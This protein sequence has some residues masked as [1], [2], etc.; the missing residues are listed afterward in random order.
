MES[1]NDRTLLKLLLVLVFAF[2]AVAFTVPDAEAYQ[3]F[4]ADTDGGTLTNCEACHPSLTDKGDGHDLHQNGTGLGCSDCHGGGLANRDA[5]PLANCVQCHG[6][7][8]DDTAG[9][10][11]S[12][13]NLP[14]LGDGLRAHHAWAG[15]AVCAG[16]HGN[17][18]TP[19]GEDVLPPYYPGEA[20]LE[21]CNGSEERFL[22][23]STTSLD[24]DGDGLTDLADP[25]CAPEICDNGVDDNGNG[26][27]DC[28]DPTCDG[29]PGPGGFTC[30]FGTELTCNDAFDNDA[31]GASD[32]ADQDCDGLD[33][34]EFGT[35]LSCF[36][37]FDNDADTLTDCA[38]LVDCDGASQG[39]NTCTVAGQQGECAKGEL[40]CDGGAEA[41]VQTVFPVPEICTNTLDN[42]C[43]G[44]LPADDPDCANVEN[45]FNG[46]DDD[47]DGLVDCADVVDCE[48]AIGDPT[49]CGLGVCAATG[50]FECS[51]GVEIDNCTPGP[52]D[53][54]LDVTC[55]GVDGD[56]DGAVDEDY[57]IDG[58]CGI[59]FCGAP[60]NTPSS[61]SGGVETLCQPGP[62]D[63][64]GPETDPT[65]GDTLDNDCDGLTDA[66][67]PDCGGTEKPPP[68]NQFLGIPDVS[69]TN[70]TEDDC[71]FC[72]NQ[73][74]PPG[75]PVDPTYLPDRHH[76]RLGMPIDFTNNTVNWDDPNSLPNR[77]AD[78]DGVDDSVFDCLNCHNVEWNPNTSSY[79][80]VVER[81]CLVCHI[82]SPHHV[83]VEATSGNCQAC[84]GT[85]VDRGLIDTTG[86][87]YADTVDAP[88]VP[89]YQ[90][91][92]VTPWP[93]GK[94]DQNYDPPYT[95]G[96]PANS[97]GTLTGNC[98]Y[99]HDS[100]TILAGIPYFIG[101]TAQDNYKNHHDTGIPD[102]ILPGNVETCWWCHNPHPYNIDPTYPQPYS[103]RT[104][105]NCHGIP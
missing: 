24:N 48:G 105:E 103:I 91:S 36:D 74:P 52:Q 70:L 32:C 34:C 29:Q 77:D 65:C 35:E 2:A 95:G 69:F 68:V 56:C 25:D 67:D 26:L 99:C 59:G 47:G 41:C 7:A 28:A 19:V 10:D 21:P 82:A 50:N 15:V 83:T 94:D 88:W 4:A 73:N 60:N 5:P 43:D 89:T 85:F 23:G 14:N 86:D 46:V 62:A 30:E 6:R 49:T 51:G 75:I 81:N 92:L 90:P 84:H 58:T 79:E 13:G 87:G 66:S 31:D 3:Y 40:Q 1:M 38:D 53:E 102:L 12:G 37:N 27:I 57:V 80:V 45:C 22:F 101:K 93:S 16:C 54:P 17:D 33:N 18:T 97:R 78:G 44:L 42:D 71:R 96:Q 11:T 20:L 63:V 64:E 39:P 72:H 104:C 98:N 100:G 8:E 9:G 76:L 61:C 55:D